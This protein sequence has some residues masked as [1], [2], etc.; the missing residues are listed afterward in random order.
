MARLAM[1]GLLTLSL[2]VLMVSGQSTYDDTRIDD[3][4]YEGLYSGLPEPGVWIEPVCPSDINETA[5]LCHRY[6]YGSIHVLKFT[7]EA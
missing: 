3:V 1:F 6:R 5:D 4:D 7:H 2:L